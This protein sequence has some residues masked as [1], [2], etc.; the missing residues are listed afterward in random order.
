LTPIC[1]PAPSTLLND[2]GDGA[3]ELLLTG[4]RLRGL[5][6]NSLQSEAS[7][8]LEEVFGE[9]DDGLT[10]RFDCCKRLGLKSLGAAFDHADE[11]TEPA[12]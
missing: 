6:G 1:C 11:L 8:L 5:G 7:D 2:V 10:D 3:A 4:D 9:R 12:C